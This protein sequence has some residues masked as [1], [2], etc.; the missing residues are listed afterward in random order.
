MK[1]ILGCPPRFFSTN[2][3]LTV[4]FILFLII[5]ATPISA[6]AQENLWYVFFPVSGWNTSGVFSV[7]GTA[8]GETSFGLTG[9]QSAFLNPAVLAGNSRP[10]ADISSRIATVAYYGNPIQDPYFEGYEKFKSDKTNF[11]SA[12]LALKINGWNLGLGY[13]IYQTFNYPDINLDTYNELTCKQSGKLDAYYLTLARRIDSWLQGGLSVA[14]ITGSIFREHSVYYMGSSSVAQYDLKIRAVL[15]NIGFVFPLSSNLDL[16]LAIRPALNL[17]V[18]ATE[19]VTDIDGEGIETTADYS[20]SYF[21]QQPFVAT[22]SLSYRP[23]ER[24]QLTADLSY[25]PWKKAAH[26]LYNLYEWEL[27]P[28]D[29]SDVDAQTEVFLD[30]ALKFNLGLEYRLHLGPGAVRDLLL[31]GG[32]I[33]DP[34]HYHLWNY[35]RYRYAPSIITAGVGLPIGNLEASAAVRVWLSPGNWDTFRYAAFQ[36]GLSYSFK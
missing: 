27:P 3:K 17:N 22:A 26:N 35:S 20:G 4:A 13:S 25:W 19:Q 5:M 11:E 23:V 21:F 29:P 1:T 12:A 32:Y 9:A 24:L 28:V 36:F 7:R 34:L 16:G 15:F 2:L 6:Q 31:R 18:K 10:V 30:N 33:Y 14:Y 8:M